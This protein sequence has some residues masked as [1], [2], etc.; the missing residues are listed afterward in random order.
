MNTIKALLTACALATLPN[1]S[2][3]WWDIE[4]SAVVNAPLPVGQYR[5]TDFRGSWHESQNVGQWTGNLIDS[6][7]SILKVTQYIDMDEETGIGKLSPFACSGSV[8]CSPAWY[9]PRGSVKNNAQIGN[10]GEAN[11]KS[12]V[13]FVPADGWTGQWTVQAGVRAMDD[14][15]NEY[16]VEYFPIVL[17]VIFHAPTPEVPVPATAWLLGSGLL[18]LACATKRKQKL[19]N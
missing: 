11:Y 9:R 13:A 12:N 3:A 6:N 10:F 18:G 15:G 16:V 17:N 7:N 2:N 4:M 19:V 14:E 5:L 1:I 8:A